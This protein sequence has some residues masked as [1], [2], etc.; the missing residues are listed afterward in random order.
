M[1]GKKTSKLSATNGTQIFKNMTDSA[2]VYAVKDEHTG[3]Y[4]SGDQKWGSLA[5]ALT[6]ETSGRANKLCETVKNQ[7]EITSEYRK[8]K[9]VPLSLNTFQ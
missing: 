6:T 7:T 4:Y 2:K 5:S 1:I 3:Y 9:V 8:P